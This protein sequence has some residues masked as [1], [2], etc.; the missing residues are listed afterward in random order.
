MCS[1][2]SKRPPMGR[3]TGDLLPLLM[4]PGTITKW[5]KRTSSLRLVQV[6]SCQGRDTH[7][8]HGGRRGLPRVIGDWLSFLFL[9]RVS[10]LESWRVS[11]RLTRNTTRNDAPRVA[12]A[13][14]LHSFPLRL[15]LEGASKH[16]ISGERSS[17]WKKTGCVAGPPLLPPP[18]STPFPASSF[19]PVRCRPY[20]VEKLPSVGDW[21]SSISDCK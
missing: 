6:F 2:M 12:A 14:L 21:P 3:P 18:P 1:P 4:Q 8:P 13:A 7:H 16:L 19:L 9:F 11:I 15:T 17:R 10:S 5:T 20:M